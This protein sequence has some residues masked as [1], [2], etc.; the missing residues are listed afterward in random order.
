MDT[1]T[2]SKGSGIELRAVRSSDREDDLALA[3]LGKKAVL[4]VRVTA[5][6]KEMDWADHHL[7]ETVR[8]PV[9]SR[10]QLHCLDHLGRIFGV[11]FHSTRD[12]SVPNSTIDCSCSASKSKSP[13]T[14]DP[15]SSN[16]HS[17]GTAGVIYGYLLVWLGTVS[18]FMVLSELVSM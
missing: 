11:S 6:D 17:G 13:A 3:K 14:S 10:L 5:A 16:Q 8:L 15:P 4:K 2:P 12:D 7:P 9:D 1:S 18:V